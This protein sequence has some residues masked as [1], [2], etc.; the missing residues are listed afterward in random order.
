MTKLKTAVGRS[1]GVGFLEDHTQVMDLVV[2][3]EPQLYQ[4]TEA[5]ATM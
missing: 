5:V 3:A 1:H 4:L 2:R